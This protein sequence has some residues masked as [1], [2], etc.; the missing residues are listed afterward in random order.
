MKTIMVKCLALVL[1]LGIISNVA[2]AQAKK[3]KPVHKTRTVKKRTTAKRTTNSKTKADINPSAKVDTAVVIAPP[4]ID[5]LPITFVKPSLRPDDAI[6][7]NLVKDRTPLPYEYL[8]EDDAVYREKVW[9][10]IDTREKMNLPFRYS[11]NEDNGNQRFISILFKAIQDGPDNGGVTVFNPSD[12]RFTTPMTVAEVAKMVAGEPV[13]V[14]MYDSLGNVTGYKQTTPEVN[15]DSFYKFEI[16]EEVIFDK[17]SSRLFWRILGIAPLKNV[18]TSQ[19]INLG[20]APLFWVY[21]PDMRPIFAKYE[22]YNGKNYG[23]R[24]SWEE[25]FE[26]RMFYGRIIKSTLNN[27]FDEMLSQQ[28]GLKQN[29]ILQLLE[30][31]NIQNKIFDYEQNLWSY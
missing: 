13:S 11:A 1:C 7:R 21:Y 2:E 23:A 19:G 6:E 18:I 12:D 29:R 3:K 14:P 8:R 5:S 24:M 16:K 25:L 15:L 30:G 4:K 26:S 20:E 27:P 9:R 28:Q 10:E 31:E 17:E 22:V